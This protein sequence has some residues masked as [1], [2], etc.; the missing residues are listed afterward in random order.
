M[1]L[2]NGK[3]PLPPGKLAAVVTYLQM[4]APPERAPVPAPDGATLTHLPTPDPDWY[5]DL[6]R[7]IGTPWLW[8][9]RLRLEREALNA[10]LTDENV[11]IHAV[12]QDGQDI[13]LVELDFRRPEVNEIAFF[14]LIP[15]ATGQGLGRWMMDQ[16]I[17]KAFATRNT[18]LFLHT[19]TLDSPAALPF[20]QS[21]GFT[22]Y[23][24]AVEILDD[25][26]F[27]ETHSISAAPQ[28]PFLQ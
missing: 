27:D 21:C 16:A 4:H 10:I 2:E 8:T 12:R 9:S 20:Y 22:A 17:R 28:I 3:H 26:R 18:R 14:G 5:L 6:F 24:R 11:L 13:G 15:S 19:C 1:T 7:E 23:K 25:P